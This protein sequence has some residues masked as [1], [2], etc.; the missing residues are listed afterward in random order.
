MKNSFLLV[1][2]SA[3]LAGKRNSLCTGSRGRAGGVD[4]CLQGRHVH[5]ERDKERCMPQAQGRQRL[6]R[7][8]YGKRGQPVD[9]PER[10]VGPQRAWRPATTPMKPKG[11]SKTSDTTT[12][13]EG[14]GAGKV[15]VNSNSK[16]YHCAGTKYYSKTKEGSYLSEAEAKTA[17]HAVCRPRE[18]VQLTK[19]CN[20]LDDLPRAVDDE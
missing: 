15:W 14:G 12:V 2:T 5:D 11:M 8:G 7:R 18:G 4:R 6:V 9:S 10:H 1:T 17:G 13:A 3:L 16:V 19:R 20:T